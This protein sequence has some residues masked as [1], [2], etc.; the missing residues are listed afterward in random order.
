M[1]A[2]RLVLDFI[3]PYRVSPD[4]DRPAAEFDKGGLAVR[5]SVL[6]GAFRVGLT[7]TNPTRTYEIKH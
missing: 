6:P 4:M 2:A 7:M 5:L 1:A 3:N